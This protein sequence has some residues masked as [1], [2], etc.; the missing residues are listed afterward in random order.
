MNNIRNRVQLIGHL[1]MDPEVK[2][3]D[4]NRKMA[5]ISMA[6]NDS[7][8]DAQGNKVEQT[9]WHKIIIWGK[10]AELAES[11]LT[12]GMEVLVEGKLINRYI[13]FLVVNSVSQFLPTYVRRY[14][15]VMA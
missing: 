4:N 3:F 1:G 9:E 5:K 7:Y 8:K 6:T 13:F 2:T 10:Q 12:K 11:M 14:L 15:F